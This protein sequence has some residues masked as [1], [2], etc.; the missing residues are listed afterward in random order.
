MFKHAAASNMLLPSAFA[1]TVE[2]RSQGESL[3]QPL[4]NRDSLL[5]LM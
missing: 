4:A 2:R 1:S 5:Y 3:Q